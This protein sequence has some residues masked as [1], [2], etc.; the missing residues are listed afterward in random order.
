MA[1]SDN[2]F[3]AKLREHADRA[4]RFF[5][6][7]QKP[8]RERMIG[9]HSFVVSGKPSKIAR[10]SRAVRSRSTSDF[11]AP[12][13]RLWRSSA[14]ES[15][16]SIGVGVKTD[17]AMHNVS[18]TCWNR[19][20]RRSRCRSM[21]R[22]SLSPIVCGRKLRAM[23][24]PHARAWMPWSISIFTTG[25]YGRLSPP[26]MGGPLPCFKPRA[27][28]RSPSSLCPIASCC[29]QRQPLRRSSGQTPGGF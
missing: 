16:V 8:E 17:I 28:D 5:S 15:A 3:L 20:R 19:T 4:Q 23:V 11:E 21:T 14:I 27:G 9:A 6:N 29:W 24:R 13:S 26:G 1:F 22:P 7:P 2:A 18:Q 10:S 12:I 25:T